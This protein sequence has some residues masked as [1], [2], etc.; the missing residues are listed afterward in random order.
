MFSLDRMER[1]GEVVIMMRSIE[2]FLGEENGATAVEY[3]VMLGLVLLSALAAIGVV[4]AET[5]NLWGDI[6][7]DMQT[8]GLGN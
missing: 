7:S 3:A 1:S 8:H 5:S 2:R 4:G 6:D